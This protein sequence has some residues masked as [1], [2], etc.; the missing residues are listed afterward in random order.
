MNKYLFLLILVLGFTHNFIYSQS[1]NLILNP[2]FED[3]DTCPLGDGRITG[4]RGA[5]GQVHYWNGAGRNTSDYFHVCGAGPHPGSKGYSVPYNAYGYQI[6]HSGYAYAGSLIVGLPTQWR[7]N[8]QGTLRKPLVAGQVYAFQV[9]VSKADWSPPVC[10]SD[11]GVVISDTAVYEPSSEVINLPTVW[12]NNPENYLQDSTDWK[13]LEGLIYP[14]G[15]EQFIIFGVFDSSQYLHSV[16]CGTTDS[17]S[18]SYTF[19]YIVD[20]MALIDTSEVDTVRM[21][22]NDSLFLNGAWRKDNYA[23]TSLIAGLPVRH[24]LKP[25]QDT[26]HVTVL[27]LPLGPGDTVLAGYVWMKTDSVLVLH[28]PSSTGCDSTVYYV[29]GNA[30]MTSLPAFLQIPVYVQ[31]LLESSQWYVDGLERQDEVKVWDI[32]GR[33]YP[34]RS[35][36]KTQYEIEGIREGIYFYHIYR[37]GKILKQGKIVKVE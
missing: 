29:C 34:V 13:K 26:S 24:Y 36:T 31:T 32:Q 14:Y 16:Y 11:F 3:K 23:Y 4:F 20:D 6:P 19:G 7:E 15:G 25:V 33:S 30:Q 18:T 5:Y 12:K 22:V 10:F 17:A 8:L 35:I 27:R 2:S 28:H 1:N 21:C 9:Y 37:E